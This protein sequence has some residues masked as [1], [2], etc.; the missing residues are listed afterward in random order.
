M[1]RELQ[2]K[3]DWIKTNGFKQYPHANKGSGGVDL[4]LCKTFHEKSKVECKCNDKAPQV[5]ITPYYWE[6]GGGYISFKL[7]L[8]G[9]DCDGLWPNIRYNLA[10]ED[11][12]E[13]FDKV[14]DNLYSAWNLLANA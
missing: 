12:E 9:E 5:V 11:L 6:F 13:S 4:I 14:I 7:E 8:T 10:E 2:D 1:N 3:I